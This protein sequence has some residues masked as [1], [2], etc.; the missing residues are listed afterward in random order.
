MPGGELT[1]PVGYWSGWLFVAIALPLLV[2]AW[3]AAATWLTRDRSVVRT[4]AWFRLWRAR[5]TH[6]RELGRIET[7]QQEG[8]LT[9][10]SAHQAVS[11]TVRSFVAEVG[12]VDAR[13]MNLAQLRESGVPEVVPVVEL[14]YP[15]AF[16]PRP[17]AEDD[18]RLETALA[19]ARDVVSG[20]RR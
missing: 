4:P 12:D 8:E 16:Q 18:E 10:R 19:D 2:V 15:P 11:A 7:A 20:W 5:R 17:A 9:T 1:D 6:L 14:V 13:T 3:Y